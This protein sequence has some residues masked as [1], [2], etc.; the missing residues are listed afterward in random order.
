[1]ICSVIEF[2]HGMQAYGF[3]QYLHV[4]YMLVHTQAFISYPYDVIAIYKFSNQIDG[5]VQDFTISVANRLEILQS[6]TKPSNQIFI[7]KLYSLVL[8]P[9]IESRFLKFIY[10]M[11]QTGIIHLVLDAW[12]IAC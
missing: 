11:L 1:M 3:L 9:P 10:V 7:H 6:C 8:N 4:K 12:C 2:R 5:F